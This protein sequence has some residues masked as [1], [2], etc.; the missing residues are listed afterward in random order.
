MP[1]HRRT[2]ASLAVAAM[3]LAA[4]APTAPQPTGGTTSAQPQLRPPAEQRLT[5]AVNG[6]VA[7][8][9][10]HFQIG[11]NGRRFDIF[12]P[13]LLPNERGEPGPGVATS[14]R[15][16]NDLTWQFTIRQD[17]RWHD[18]QPLTVDDVKFTFDRATNRSLQ[19]GIT[20]RV[21]TIESTRIVDRQ[22]VEI[23]TLEPDPILLRKL[24]IVAIVPQHYL[25]RV[26][27]QQFG[28]QAIGSGP[29]RVREFR[30]GELLVLTAFDEHPF[31][32][33]TL[34]E[35]VIRN[36][37]EASARIAGLQTGEVDIATLLPVEQADRL[38]QQGFAVS[39]GN[40]GA[41]IGYYMQT[42]NG[43]QPVTG[44][45]ASR[46][47]R[48][49]INYA[50]NKE[51]IAQQIYRGFTR[52]ESQV[53]Q[54]ETFGFNPNLQPYPYNPQRAREL[55]AQAGYPNGFSLRI[56]NAT[57]LAEFQPIA[58]LIQQNLRDVGI[59]AEIITLADI[60]LWR[61]K[62]NGRAPRAELF[63]VPLN[64][65]P[66]MDADFS[67]QW[68]WSRNLARIYNNPEFDRV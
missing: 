11:Q 50:V 66:A 43:D 62:F 25:E 17:M 54:P 63:S 6:L 28:V 55:L 51:I 42:V 30:S 67:L 61:E 48:Q 45:M 46:L 10:Q 47:V 41:S 18:G 1:R 15:L 14:W 23:R 56:E 57:V 9:D 35:V 38:R 36:V 60:S 32:K 19:L 58:L 3:I 27:A 26:G 12:D 8:L 5:M 20:S 21:A 7:T 52:P 59:T 29:F 34:R 68:F 31:R 33:P 44:P 16:V 49:A 37:P 13:L 4:C 2:I 40:A 53:A 39:V 22:T 65:S 64:N 24:M